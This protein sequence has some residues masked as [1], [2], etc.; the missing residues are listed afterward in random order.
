MSVQLRN[1]QSEGKGTW[2]DI[3]LFLQLHLS[4]ARSLL[5]DPQRSD[6]GHNQSVSAIMIP[7]INLSPHDLWARLGPA[8]WKTQRIFIQSL[9]MISNID[10]SGKHDVGLTELLILCFHFTCIKFFKSLAQG[11]SDFLSRRKTTVSN[12][13][14]EFQILFS[15]KSVIRSEW[16]FSPWLSN[17]DNELRVSISNQELWLQSASTSFQKWSPDMGAHIWQIQIIDQTFK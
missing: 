15:I 9:Y 16:L 10:L 14:V 4:T 12:S 17:H 6:L 3:T 8:K 13:C 7:S 1:D 2:K 11:S 5:Y